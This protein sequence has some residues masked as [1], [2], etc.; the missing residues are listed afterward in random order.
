MSIAPDA[1]QQALQPVPPQS[2]AFPDLLYSEVEEDLRASVRS[3]LADVSPHSA[4]LA[5]CETNQPYDPAVWNAL[6]V[7]LGCAGLAIG[8]EHGGAGASWREAAVVAEEVGRAAAPLPFLTSSVVASAALLALPGPLPGP[9][10]AG[11][12]A[13]L[14]RG[15]E[16]LEALAGGRLTAV[17]AAPFS[18]SPYFPETGAALP[19]SVR[20]DRG[21]RLTGTVRSVADASVA[22]LFLVP[23]STGSGPALFAVEARAEG[24]VREAVT[25]LDLTRPLSDLTFDGACARVLARG[26]HATR[27]VT[28]ALT[29]GAALLASEQLGVAQAC[30]DLSVAYLKTRTQFG[31]LIGSYQALKHRAADLWATVAQARAVARYAAACVAQDDPDTPVAVALAQSFCSSAAVRAAEECV[32]FHG[33]IGFTW[34]H[35]AH[36]YLKRAKSAALAFGSAAQH[37]AA[38]GRFVDLPAS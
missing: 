13:E 14:D 6:A 7:D 9:P 17:L 26:D 36:L 25:T 3:L 33:G 15:A 31:R 18:C 19:G 1:P 4:V 23:A 10:G 21:G 11:A 27:A 28:R 2:A 5:R 35:P 34:E 16:L 32:Q 12:S 38:I 24:V 30:L 22:D 20:A 8:E 29:A 37:R